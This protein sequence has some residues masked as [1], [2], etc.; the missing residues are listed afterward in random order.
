MYI[1]PGVYVGIQRDWGDR[2]ETQI[3]RSAEQIMIDEGFD[4]GRGANGEIQFLLVRWSG[5]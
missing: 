1:E 2:P 5:L 4:T 3:P